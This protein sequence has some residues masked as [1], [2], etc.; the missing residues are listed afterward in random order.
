MRPTRL[1]ILAETTE[2]EIHTLAWPS[3]D[4]RLVAAHTDTCAALGVPVKYTL[5]QLPHGQ[6]MDSVLAD[7]RADVVGFL[8][9]DCVPTN[10]AIVPAAVRY[11]TQ[12]Q[13]FIGTAGASNHIPPRS[14]IFA[15]PAFFF[16][17]RET[18]NRLNMP[19]FA[20]TEYGDVAENVCYTAEIAGLR[21]RTLFP[22]HYTRP[23]D[24]GAWHLHTYGLFGIGTVF[25]G[26][27]YHLYQGR[28]TRNVDLFV[29]VCRAV[30]EGRFTTEGLTPSRPTLG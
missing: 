7:S 3:C 12:S 16:I 9:I 29:E 27:V 8:D 28:F 15:A 24:E 20:E 22:T 25:E 11:V 17:W 1:R 18:W 2:L 14:H 26:G 5:E 10:D 23:P 19:T 13:S 30:R 4:P 6:W 21:Y